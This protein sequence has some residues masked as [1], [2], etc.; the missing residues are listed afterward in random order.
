MHRTYEL[1]TLLLIEGIS[2]P[3][4]AGQ[5]SFSVN[6]PAVATFDLVPLKEILDIRPRTFVQFFVKDYMGDNNFK[7]MF[8]GEVYAFGF[9]VH[10][11]GHRAFRIEC[12]DMTNYW[13]H[14]QLR[15]MDLSAETLTTK[16]FYV[17]TTTGTSKPIPIVSDPTNY[18]AQELAK[19]M[20]ENKNDVPVVLRAFIDKFGNINEFYK[21]NST[22]YNMNGRVHAASSGNIV[23]MLK[24]EPTEK[25]F[26]GIIENRGGDASFRSLVNYFLNQCFHEVITVPF[27]T[28]SGGNLKQFV[29]KP[30]SLT[31]APPVCNVV[32]P[33]Q[34]FDMNISRNFFAEA[35]RVLVKAPPSALIGGVNSTLDKIFPAPGFYERFYKAQTPFDTTYSG[36]TDSQTSVGI[37]NATYGSPAIP[38]EYAKVGNMDFMNFSKEE[39]MKGIFAAPTQIIPDILQYMIEQSAQNKTQE[40]VDNMMANTAYFMYYKGRYAQ[41][42]SII[43]GRLNFS[44][45]PGFPILFIDDQDSSMNVVAALDTITHSFSVG[46]GSNTTYH[47]SHARQTEEKADFGASTFSEPPVPPWFDKSVFGTT[48]SADSVISQSGAGKR[49]RDSLTDK[50]GKKLSIAGFVTNFGTGMNSYYQSLLGC[51]ACTDGKHLTIMEAARRYADGFSDAEDKEAYVRDIA[52]RRY[53]SLEEAM[54]FMGATGSI[55]VGPTS[56]RAKYS[57]GRLTVG[58][59]MYGTI[60]NER[61]SIIE[62]YVAR[63]NSNKSFSGS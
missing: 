17:G 11:A 33:N 55:S 60:L 37:N 51:N 34:Y 42:T 47:V 39:Y 1:S 52:K 40:D 19:L 4:S 7:V 10:A 14:A 43:T 9:T 56:V 44:P 28:Y 58:S 31:L 26:H 2:V 50:D 62:R 18:I 25:L 13:D 30:N 12:M 24:F 21:N 38:H 59:G 46:G 16:E 63:L 20:A 36:Y 49:I 6:Q 48:Q 8:E 54:K 29:F 23:N 61:R 45:V 32:F 41:R 35:T 27:P 3:L 57:G 15:F 22:R 5:V 53:A